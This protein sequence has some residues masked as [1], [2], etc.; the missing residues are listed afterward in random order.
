MKNMKYIIAD[1]VKFYR[2]RENLTQIELAE[3]AELSLDSVK[4]IEG[5]KRTMSL[6]NF[7][8]LSEALQI[9]L[10]FL[11]YEQKDKVPEEEQIKS[12]LE[13]RSDGQKRYLLHV[14][15]EMSNGMDRLL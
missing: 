6:E 14:L 5:G 13:G 8:R 2:K 1:N 12:I 4:R 10:S 3:H 9:P 11:L 15:R 7:L